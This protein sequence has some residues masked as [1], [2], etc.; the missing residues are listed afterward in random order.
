MMYLERV[1]NQVGVIFLGTVRKCVT[2]DVSRYMVRQHIGS[3][4]SLYIR[5]DVR[6]RD[7]HHFLDKFRLMAEMMSLEEITKHVIIYI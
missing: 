3:I 7:Q 5:G 2:G 4:R 6:R 1:S